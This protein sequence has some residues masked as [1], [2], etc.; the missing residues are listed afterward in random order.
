MILYLQEKYIQDLINA[1]PNQRPSA[2]ELLEGSL[3]LT[4]DEVNCLF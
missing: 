3:I 4:K 1:D 2:R